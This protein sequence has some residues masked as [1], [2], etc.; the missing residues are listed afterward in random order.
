VDAE[1]AEDGSYV[2][3]KFS[4]MNKTKKIEEKIKKT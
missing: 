4:R 1:E 3:R 2:T